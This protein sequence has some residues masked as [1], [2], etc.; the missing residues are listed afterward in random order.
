M[1]F[2]NT[3]FLLALAALAV[4]VLAGILTRSPRVYANDDDN[5]SKIQ[6]GF[7]IAPVP[8]NLDRKNRA[9]VGLGSYIVNAQG[10]CNGCHG[11][12]RVLTD[13]G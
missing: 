10:D 1:K 2:R 6:V 8:L 13:L 7:K 9:L 3:P 4:V 12:C 11:R 5:E